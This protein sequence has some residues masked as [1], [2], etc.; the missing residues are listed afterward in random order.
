MLG[1]DYIRNDHCCS[2]VLLVYV[3]VYVFPLLIVV[4]ECLSQDHDP[5]MLSY[6]RSTQISVCVLRS[7][8]RLTKKTEQLKT[9]QSFELCGFYRNSFT[10]QRILLSQQ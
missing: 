6:G 3:K 4:C 7:L 2:S 8:N 9:E 1:F 5:M 10:A